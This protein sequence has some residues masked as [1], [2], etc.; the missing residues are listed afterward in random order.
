MEYDLEDITKEWSVDLLV[1][2]DP[3]EM[4]DVDSSEIALDTVRPSKIKNTKEVHDI[5]SASM[6]TASIS[7]EEGGDGE[8]LDG[9]EVEQNKSEVTP[10]RDKEDPSKKRKV[11]PLKP[12]SRNK[13]KATRTKFET[14]LTSDNFNFIVATLNDASSEIAEKKEAKKEEV[15]SQ[16]K[17]ELQGVQQALQSSRIVST[18]PLSRET[19]EVDDAPSQLLDY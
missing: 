7:V 15:F 1:L 19:P 14:T 12:S 11:S 3:M 18:V 4:S 9:I 10:P 16:I 13:M 17:D 8:E 2:A 5:D 6:K